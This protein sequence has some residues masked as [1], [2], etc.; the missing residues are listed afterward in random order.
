MGEMYFFSFILILW[1]YKHY[2]NC[3]FYLISVVNNIKLT[4]TNVQ[5]LLAI[6][7]SGM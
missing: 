3:Q 7:E 2:F 6:F 5:A 4:A 1:E